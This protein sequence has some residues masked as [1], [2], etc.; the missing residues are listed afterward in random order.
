M[1]PQDGLKL[2][3]T[4][5]SLPSMMQNKQF[6]A[7]R[8]GQLLCNLQTYYLAD[9]N[10]RNKRSQLAEITRRT[11]GY[12]QRQDALYELDNQVYTTLLDEQTKANRLLTQAEIKTIVG[13]VFAQVAVGEKRSKAKLSSLTGRDEETGE[14]T[15]IDT[16]DQGTVGAEATLQAQQ[17]VKTFAS[18]GINAAQ[19]AVLDELYADNKSTNR[20]DTLRKQVGCSRSQANVLWNS[21]MYIRLSFMSENAWD[22]LPEAPIL[23][24]QVNELRQGPQQP[25]PTAPSSVIPFRR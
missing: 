5:K 1:A 14:A 21:Y 3:G 9:A 7:S 19:L 8:E 11:S 24:Q 22:V 18:Y 6:M 12:T 4:F 25:T 16:E 10:D 15:S 13:R 17:R 23:W 2:G 20:M